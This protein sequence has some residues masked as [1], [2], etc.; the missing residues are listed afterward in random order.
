MA[1][2]RETEFRDFVVARQAA[3]LHTATLL[4]GDRA[5]GEDL[6]Q[7]ALTKTYLAWHRIADRGAVEAYVRRVMARTAI[8]WWRRRWRGERPT[9]SPPEIRVPDHA[10]R[11]VT[12]HV[13]WQAIRTLPP[14][15][16][17]V[18]VLRFHAD[19][20]EAQTA[21]TLGVTVGTVKSQ[22]ARALRRLRGEL[23]D[24]TNTMSGAAGE[25]ASVLEG[26]L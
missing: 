3:L 15:Q 26:G 4:A 6:L 5:A 17:A 10:D 22:T 8:S 14:R 21:V 13:V 18:L 7:T 16:R 23:G 2:G 24:E 19:L 12:T 25:T 1:S 9:E 20:T 11:A